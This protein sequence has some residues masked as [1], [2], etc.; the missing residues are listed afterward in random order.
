MSECQHDFIVIHTS[1]GAASD[2]VV[3]WCRRCGVTRVDEDYNGN[4]TTREV[5]VPERSRKP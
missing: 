4:T 3:R 5:Y 1:Y 2:Y